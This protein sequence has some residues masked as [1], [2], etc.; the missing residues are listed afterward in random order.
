MHQDFSIFY[1]HDTFFMSAKI[2]FIETKINFSQKS[3][4]RTLNSRRW[5]EGAVDE[6]AKD[7]CQF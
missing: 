5:D 6:I 7:G 1:H 3:I 4:K 2:N